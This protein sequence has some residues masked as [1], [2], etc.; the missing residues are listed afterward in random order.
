MKFST[1]TRQSCGAVIERRPPQ[2]S[3]VLYFDRA[4]GETVHFLLRCE[5]SS[6]TDF[7]W[8]TGR[9]YEKDL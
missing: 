4:T 5:M 3:L 9:A 8:G 6:E 1:H 2:R 7:C